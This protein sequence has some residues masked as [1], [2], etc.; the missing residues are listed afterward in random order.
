MRARGIN[1]GRSKLTD[2]EVKLIR[3]YRWDKRMTYKNIAKMFPVSQT[4]I[5]RICQDL[6]W[7]PPEDRANE[8]N[9]HC[10]D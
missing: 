5:W 1:H 9:K 3:K 2:E 7:A 6:I 4:N 8:K 10:T